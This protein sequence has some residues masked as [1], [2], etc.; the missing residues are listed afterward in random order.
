MATRWHVLQFRRDTAI[1]ERSNKTLNAFEKLR[2]GGL[3][4]GYGDDLAGVNAVRQHQSHAPGHQSG[5]AAAGA[6]LDE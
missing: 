6:G 5:L 2:G 1:A 3:G 4:E